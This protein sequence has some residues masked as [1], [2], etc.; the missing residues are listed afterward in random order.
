MAE[1]LIRAAH[2]GAWTA[3]VSHDWIQLDRE[4]T[5]AFGNEHLICMTTY[6][7]YHRLP[8]GTTPENVPRAGGFVS[9]SGNIYFRIGLDS[10]ND[11]LI[12]ARNR[13]PE[14]QDG[15]E[16]RW[17]QVI[18]RHSG[19]T[20]IIWIRQG[21][22]TAELMRAGDAP[23]ANNNTSRIAENIIS[24][25]PFNLTAVHLNQYVSS[26]AEQLEGTALNNSI[27][28]RYPS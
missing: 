2:T 7:E 27:F 8:D 10:Y 24:F 3:T 17:G 25:S 1:R 19:G 20:H 26:R 5:W 14:N 28:V 21:E 12:N 11:N 6:D 13:T 15:R 9:G 18:V 16:P 23:N 4:M 22:D